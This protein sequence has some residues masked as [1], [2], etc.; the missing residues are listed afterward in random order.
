[1]PF[2]QSSISAHARL[3]VPLVC[4]FSYL[5]KDCFFFSPGDV[6]EERFNE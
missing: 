2:Q 3:F 6:S 4:I 1:M 5:L